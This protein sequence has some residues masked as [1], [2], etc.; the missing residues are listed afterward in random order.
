M[1]GSRR[2]HNDKGFRAWIARTLC[3]EVEQVR[4]TVDH[5]MHVSYKPH[6]RGTVV[7]RT[8]YEDET[9][10]L[11]ERYQAEKAAEELKS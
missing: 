2:I 8:F 9:F 3:G 4:I 1:A 5:E 11:F 7:S 10:E 6:G